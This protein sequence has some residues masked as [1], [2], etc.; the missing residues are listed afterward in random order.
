MII[1]GCKPVNIKITADLLT[2]QRIQ[3]NINLKNFAR[4]LSISFFTINGPKN[5][6]VFVARPSKLNEIQ[7]TNI[8]SAITIGSN[9]VQQ[10]DIN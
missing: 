9:I 6:E 2:I 5:K 3:D 7:G 10:K 4:V 8:I 1:K